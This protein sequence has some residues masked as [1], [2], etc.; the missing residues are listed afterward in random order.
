MKNVYWFPFIFLFIFVSCKSS[1]QEQRPKSLKA[2]FLN[3]YFKEKSNQFKFYNRTE[4]NFAFP[5][6]ENYSDYG[7]FVWDYEFLKE[8]S[9]RI[10]TVLKR[11][12]DSLVPGQA[13]LDSLENQVSPPIILSHRSSSDYNLEFIKSKTPFRD[14]SKKGAFR[15]ISNPLITPD[16]N[17]CFLY[18][19]TIVRSKESKQEIQIR[20]M[21][22]YEKKAGNSW[23]AV[24]FFHIWNLKEGDEIPI[25]KGEPETFSKH[26]PQK[27]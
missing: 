20:Q 26:L 7:G 5:R 4:T 17:H 11:D 19:F 14:A 15:M 10:V 27:N 23:K 2:S 25:R 18:E 1:K 16:G 6:Q 12:F 22:V 3:W 21:K 13:I 9:K 24:G 8:K